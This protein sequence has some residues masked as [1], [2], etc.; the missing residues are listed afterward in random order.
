M[1]PMFRKE[2]SQKG[3]IL[4]RLIISLKFRFELSSL[5]FPK[6]IKNAYVNRLQKEL[7]ALMMSTEKSVSAFPENEN[8]FRWIGTITG[9]ILGNDDSV[10]F[11]FKQNKN[12]FSLI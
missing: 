2:A 4:T 7:M 6:T 12:F 9:K 11:K 10:F 5:N 3:K 1:N 8:F